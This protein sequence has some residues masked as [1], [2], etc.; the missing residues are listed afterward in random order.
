VKILLSFAQF[1]REVIGERIRYKMAASRMKGIWM[2]GYVPLGHDV[3]DRKLVVN[4]RDACSVRRIFDRFVEVG[5]AT[6]LAREL[7]REGFRSKQGTLIDKGYLYRLLNWS[8]PTE[9]VH[10]L[11]YD[12]PT[13]WR[14]RRWLESERSRKTL[15]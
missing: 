14:T 4:E 7:R 10:Q 5:S 9:V 2:G 15:F 6:V 12:D 8:A 1:E 13:F 11:G 3:R